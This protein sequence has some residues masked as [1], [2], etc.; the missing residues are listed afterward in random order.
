MARHLV[1]SDRILEVMRYIPDCGL[2]DLVLNCKDFPLQTVLSAVSR[3]S[4]EGQLHLTLGSSGSFTVQLL[5]VNSQSRLV[6]GFL[7]REKTM[8]KDNAKSQKGH[9][10]RRSDTMRKWDRKRVLQPSSVH[11]TCNEVEL[12]SLMSKGEST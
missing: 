7:A 4:R 2:D 1:A 3:L 6:K 9:N 5:S 10:D 8:G 11:L 12:E